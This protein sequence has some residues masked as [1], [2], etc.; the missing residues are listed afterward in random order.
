MLERKYVSEFALHTYSS[1]VTICYPN[2][3]RTLNLESKNHIYMVTLIPKLT[4]NPDSLEIFEDH[5]SFKVNIK[6]E[7]E[8]TSH[9]IKVGITPDNHKDFEYRFDKPL[10]TLFVKNKNG[11]EFGIRVLWLYLEA[12]GNYLDAEIMYIGQSFGKEGERDAFDRLK[13]HSTLQKIQS[14]ILFEEPDNDIAIILFE[15][16]PRLLASFDGLTKQF[17]KSLEEDNEHF[18]SV[19]DQPPLE[20]TKPIITITEAALIHYFKPK[21]NTNFKNNFPD[22]DHIYKEFYELDYNAVLVELD[23]DA[24]NV[25]LFSK[26]KEYNP[27]EHIEYT[28]HP[29]NVRKNMFEI[30]G[31]NEK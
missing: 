10:K 20:L 6:T 27:F 29:E 17:E 22:S 5:I 21:Y 18:L 16:T 8:N 30:F 4:F 9:E 7:V 26:E 28:L 12:S 13:S 24:I 14:D 23:M 1:Y 31:E 15:F 19:I 2:D 11:A 25:N 3:L